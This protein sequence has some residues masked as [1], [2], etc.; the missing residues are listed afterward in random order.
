MVL[1]VAPVLGIGAAAVAQYP[2]EVVLLVNPS[3][4]SVGAHFT[5]T[6]EGCTTGEVV[7]FSLVSDAD[8]ATCAAGVAS[9]TLTAPDA[10]GTYTVTASASGGT[11]TATLRVVDPDD[12]DAEIPQAGSDSLPIVRIG[13]AVLVAGLALVSVAWYRRRSAAA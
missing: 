1:A 4:V 5:A 2:P 10:A 12:V 8:S 13:G 6:F 7:N 11:A 3:T 9:V